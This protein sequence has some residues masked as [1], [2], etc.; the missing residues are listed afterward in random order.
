MRLTKGFYKGQ[1][2]IPPFDGV[3]MIEY[4]DHVALTPM[5]SC[6]EFVGLGKIKASKLQPK[7]WGGFSSIWLQTLGDK[8]LWVVVR[9]ERYGDGREQPTLMNLMD[10]TE[11][12]ARRA[13]RDMVKF[14]RLTKKELD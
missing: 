1:G 2:I 13:V 6:R 8:E 3:R 5:Y 11:T 10:G 14:C 7:K 4:A 12:E 9:W